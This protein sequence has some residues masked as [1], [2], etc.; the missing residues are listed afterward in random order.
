MQNKNLYFIAYLICAPVI[1][2]IWYVIV[3]PILY[4]KKIL[5]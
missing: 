4:I 3:K 5:F 2:F 1:Y